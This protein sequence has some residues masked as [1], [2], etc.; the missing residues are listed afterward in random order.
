MSHVPGSVSALQM[1]IY[2]YT[3]TCRCLS[4]KYSPTSGEVCFRGE[5]EAGLLIVSSVSIATRHGEID[6]VLRLFL[7]LV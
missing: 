2:I 3:H 5:V 4:D 1:F 7:G 6:S